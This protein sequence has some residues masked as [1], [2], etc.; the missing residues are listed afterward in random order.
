MKPG[1]VEEPVQA[2]LAGGPK[3][4]RNHNE[5]P[6]S[7]AYHKGQLQNGIVR[8]PDGLS[9]YTAAERYA[10]GEEFRQAWEVIGG[11]GRDSTDGDRINGNGNE[12][13][14]IIKTSAELY[15]RRVK[16]ALSPR[17]WMIV[18]HVCGEGWWPSEAV[19]DAC[20][21]SY[22]HATIPRLNE[23]LDNLIEARRA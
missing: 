2:H 11:S 8:G 16:H 20:G 7:L 4:F 17:D 6:L 22:V 13:V 14:T 18:Q 9:K 21:P 12:P 1:Y 23:A 10:A 5:H 3:R 19:R 15:R